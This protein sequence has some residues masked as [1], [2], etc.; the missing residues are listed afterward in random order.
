MR[1]LSI[2]CV[3]LALAVTASLATAQ[4]SPMRPGRYE[5]TAQMEMPNM[6]VQMPAMKNTQCVTQQQI[7]GQTKGVP[8]GPQKNPNDCK[9]SDYKVSGNTVTWNMAC[10]GQQPMT[11]SGEMRFNGDSYEGTMKMMMQG[12]EMSMKLSG[13]R[14]GDCTQ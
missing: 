10:T 5:V 14:L 9:V 2:L 4:S 1:P 6:P 12:M 11:G 3:A 13:K 7:D 8:M